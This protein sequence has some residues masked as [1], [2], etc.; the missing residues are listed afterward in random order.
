MALRNK[1]AKILGH[2]MTSGE[3]SIIVYYS[4]IQLCDAV[5]SKS[6]EVLGKELTSLQIQAFFIDTGMKEA[7]KD[8]LLEPF[9]AGTT[10]QVKH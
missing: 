10:S 6:V 3:K 2:K 9:D 5:A 4:F 7:T 8:Q 1:E